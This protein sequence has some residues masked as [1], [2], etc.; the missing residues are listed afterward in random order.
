MP[1]QLTAEDYEI[2]D[3]ATRNE[4]YTHRH[5]P[6]DVLRAIVGADVIPPTREQRRAAPPTGRRLRG[7]R[8]RFRL[9]RLRNRPAPGEDIAVSA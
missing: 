6:H 7:I 9:A 8:L 5:W 3:L 1:K 2:V 4:R